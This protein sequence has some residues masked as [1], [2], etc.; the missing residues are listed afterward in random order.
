MHDMSAAFAESTKE[1]S[2]T[3]PEEVAVASPPLQR[4]IIAEDLKWTPATAPRL[5]A[6]CLHSIV[7]N[8]A[9]RPTLQIPKKHLETV[10]K[11]LPTSLPVSITAG[12][13]HSDTYWR[14]A[15]NDKWPALNPA[16]NTW[17]AIYFQHFIAD[18][19]ETIYPGQAEEVA[20][21]IQV[22]SPYIKSLEIKQLRPVYLATAKPVG[23]GTASGWSVFN[24][25]RKQEIEKDDKEHS[26]DTLPVMSAPPN[27]VLIPNLQIPSRLPKE[28]KDR[29][30]EADHVDMRIILNN[31]KNLENLSVT[32]G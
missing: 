23:N 15:A 27:Q 11:T 13:I 21:I 1:V 32:F 16:G 17:K 8:F 18:L 7:E 12:I 25:L 5:S 26:Q 9:T 3:I 4:R 29:L 19:I 6:L 20:K 22:S 10:Y 30:P 14:R 2:Q 24:Y 31:L 28:G